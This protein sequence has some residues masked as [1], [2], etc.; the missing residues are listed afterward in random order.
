MTQLNRLPLVALIP[1]L[2]IMLRKLYLANFIE[3]GNGAFGI[4]RVL[5]DADS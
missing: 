1:V 3:I 5:G 4:I 2:R